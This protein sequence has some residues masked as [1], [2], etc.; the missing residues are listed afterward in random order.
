MVSLSG[1]RPPEGASARVSPCLDAACGSRATRARL[2]CSLT[3]PIWGFHPKCSCITFCLS[4]PLSVSCHCPATVVCAFECQSESGRPFIYVFR[5][6]VLVIICVSY[7]CGRSPLH[8]H[9]SSYG[10]PS[11]RPEVQ[12]FPGAWR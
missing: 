2:N 1:P 7:S 12:R 4:T 9:L 11:Y 10:C 6:L 8:C 5:R 3:C